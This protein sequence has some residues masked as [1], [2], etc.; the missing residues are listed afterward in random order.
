MAD[1]AEPTDIIRHRNQLT[2]IINVNSILLSDV[3][4][5]DKETYPVDIDENAPATDLVELGFVSVSEVSK[6]WRSMAE[7]L[8]IRC[9]HLSQ[10]FVSEPFAF[11]CCDVSNP[12]VRDESADVVES[13]VKTPSTDKIK[14]NIITV[15]GT[16]TCHLAIENINAPA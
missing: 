3:V 8:G 11:T 12:R 4:P 2:V 6:R 1:M 15:D 14:N 10:C 5:R 16:F 13:D 7:S 9:E